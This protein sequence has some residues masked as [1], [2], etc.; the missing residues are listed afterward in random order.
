MLL[1]ASVPTR[2]QQPLRTGRTGVVPEVI[3][4]SR[5]TI[6]LF[7]RSASCRT[8]QCPGGQPFRHNRYRHPGWVVLQTAA[9]FTAGST[10]EP[11]T[12]PAWDMPESARPPSKSATATSRTCRWRCASMSSARPP[13]IQTCCRRA[14]H[15]MTEFTADKRMFERGRGTPLPL[16]AIPRGTPAGPRERLHRRAR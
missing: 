8:S 4:R 11:A 1:P 16:G 14:Y 3:S 10:Q 15:P 6:R 7:A 13:W 9:G 12:I 2:K 5:L